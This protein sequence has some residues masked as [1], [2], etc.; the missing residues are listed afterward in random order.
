MR[1]ALILALAAATTTLAVPTP[2]FGIDFD[3]LGSLLSKIK[4]LAGQK[5]VI[6][7]HGN[8]GTV[9][10]RPPTPPE[11]CN[12]LCS[13]DKYGDAG[14]HIN[15]GNNWYQCAYPHSACT[16]NDVSEQG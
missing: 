15:Q 10:P 14:V 16:W 9:V 4:A 3:F 1:T 12:C 13:P 8:G 6:I 7:K 11:M 2:T 5:C